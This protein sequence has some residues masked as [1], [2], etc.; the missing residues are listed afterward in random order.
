M[1]GQIDHQIIVSADGSHT[2]YLPL[3]DETYHS[4]HGAIAESRYVYL[5]HGL[6]TLGLKYIKV[7]EIGFGTGLNALLT[8]QY[9]QANNI[10]IDYETL[11]PYRLAEGIFSQLNYGR[12]LSDASIFTA[13]HNAVANE[14]IELSSDF[15]ICIRPTTIQEFE[16]SQTYDIIYF[17]AFA[18]SK[19]PEMWEIPIL[20]KLFS[21]LNA[22]GILVT[23]CAKG[24]FRR[25]L[26]A[27]GFKV[28]VLEGPPPK[29]QMFRGRKNKVAS[30]L[31]YYNKEI[32]S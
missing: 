17:D 22:G 7:L 18:P 8:Y 15:N 1:E 10:S 13:L 27:A 24:Q 23:Y 31:S 9:A 28:E 29:K 25:N 26:I 6:Q 16:T 14:K 11:E 30:Y 4:S 32:V 21:L 20:K 12:I 3:L 5:Q 2:I 19:Q